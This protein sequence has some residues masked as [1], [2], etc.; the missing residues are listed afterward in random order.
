[1]FWFKNFSIEVIVIVHKEQV[2]SSA[3]ILQELS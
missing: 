2:L 3:A 1:M